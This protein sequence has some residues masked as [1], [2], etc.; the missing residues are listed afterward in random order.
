MFGEHRRNRKIRRENKRRESQAAFDRAERETQNLPT[1]EYDQ[2]RQASSQA[3]DRGRADRDARRKEHL[4]TSREEVTQD[5]PGLTPQQ[6][7]VLQEQAAAEIDR[8]FDR[9]NREILSSA[10]SRGMRG[11]TVFAQQKDLAERSAEAKRGV[12]RD[13]NREDI[14]L[15]NQRL[16]ASLAQ[17]EGKVSQDLAEEQK[18][19]DWLEARR[20]QRRQ[21]ALG[22]ARQQDYNRV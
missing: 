15:Q 22:R 19:Q 14:D 10:G 6:R 4:R 2:L 3:A 12:Q 16:A 17:T 5:I 18:A 8:D 1:K 20:E 21:Q 9:Y 7:R 11:G 13:L